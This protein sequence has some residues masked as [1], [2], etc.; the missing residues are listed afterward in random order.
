M[1]SFFFPQMKQV[2]D[3]FPG[4]SAVVLTAHRSLNLLGSSGPPASASK[5]AAAIGVC[6]HTRLSYLY[7]YFYFTLFYYYFFFRWIFALVAQAGVQWQDL[8]SVRP[9]PA[10][11]K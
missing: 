6:H 5:V 3:L 8:G 11:F 1:A 9:L 4:W 10:R 2:L 7:C